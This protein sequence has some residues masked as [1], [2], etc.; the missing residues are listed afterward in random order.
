MIFFFLGE[1]RGCAWLFCLW[2]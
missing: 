1:D 2:C